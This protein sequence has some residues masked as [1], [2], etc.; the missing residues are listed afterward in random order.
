MPLTMDRGR[1]PTL[2]AER[3]SSIQVRSVDNQEVRPESIRLA[4]INNMPDTAL[5]DTELQFFEL[6]ESAAGDLAVHISLYSLP[7]L[8]RGDRGQKHL[9]SFYLDVDD[10]LND[11]F[12]ATIITGTEP[13]RPTLPDEPYWPRLVEVLDW[14]EHNTVS[15]ILSCL[16]AHAGVLYSDGIERIRLSEK[17]FGVFDHEKLCD[18][19][20][21]SGSPNPVRAPHSR[22]NDLQE[23]AL[24]DSGYIVLT[25]SAV[26]GVDMFV[27]E[28]KRSLFV[29]FQGH[30]EYG[31]ESLLKEYRRDIKRFLR[32]EIEGY[33][34][35]PQG[36]FGA[37]A[38]KVLT[39]FEGT[40]RS[41]TREELLAAFPQPFVLGT[42]QNTWRSS[43]TGVYRNWLQYVALR[44]ADGA[45]LHRTHPSGNEWRTKQP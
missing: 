4:F 22:W 7:E 12:D 43:A 2:W 32:R 28:K 16:A 21:T 9:N 41:D 19:A 45:T 1:I 14:A 34:S 10:L 20:L 8:P 5:E 18:H 36:Y 27:K 11:R 6:L 37:A 38:T 35:I 13:R 23:E 39:D 33:P 3:R 44:K 29:H 26:A 40:A 24:T 25:K 15:T 30:P 42:F 17:R 31:T